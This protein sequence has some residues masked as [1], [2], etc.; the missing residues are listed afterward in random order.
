MQNNLLHQS[1]TSTEI[2]GG[3][4]ALMVVKC[5]LVISDV[6]G[7]IT[8]S[9]LL[10]H[11]LPRVGFDWSHPGI[12][13]LFSSIEKNGYHILFLSS[14]AIAQVADLS[15]GTGCRKA[16]AGCPKA[17]PDALCSPAGKR[18]A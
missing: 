5:R 14:R 6:D 18:D 2:N 17:A 3:S 16:T 4:R 9:D 1:T 8:K 7:T 10:G 12:N 15:P 13:K 11:V